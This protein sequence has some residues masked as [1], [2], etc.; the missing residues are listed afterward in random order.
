MRVAMVTGEDRQEPGAQ[1][2]PLL[3]CVAAAVGQRATRHPGLVDP[4]GGQKLGEKCQLGVRRRAG[5]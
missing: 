5:L 1:N 3:G 2:V 4:G